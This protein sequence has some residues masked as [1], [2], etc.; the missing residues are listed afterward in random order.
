[1]RASAIL[2]VLAGCTGTTTPPAPEP[3]APEPQVPERALAVAMSRFVAGEDGVQTQPARVSFL[4]PDGAVLGQLEDPESNVFHK[5]MPFRGGLLT[6]G[7]DKARVVHWTRQGQT[8]TAEQVLWQAS[9]GGEHDRM[10]DI[11]LGD[12]DGDGNQE[13]VVATHDQGVVAVLDQA[14]DDS[15]TWTA[16]EL[17]RTPSTFVHEIELGDLDG[18]GTL[19][20]YATPSQPNRSSGA[21]Q[22][23]R[24]DR[25][26][27]GAQGYAHS[28]VVELSDT[29]AKEILVTDLGSG[30]QLFAVAEG[31]V[32][33]AGGLKEPVRIL[34]LDPPAAESSDQTWTSVP[35][36]TLLGE[37]Q[38]RFLVPGDVDGDGS[39]ELVATGMTS[40]VWLLEP[41]PE[42]TLSA[43]QVD[44]SSGGF[45]QAA[46][47]ADLDGDG[48]P[49]LYV[50]SEPGRGAP[51]QLRR[52]AWTEGRSKREVLH[53]FQGDGIVWGIADVRWGE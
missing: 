30:D 32:G 38:S 13:L 6:I 42:G 9:F 46:H 44:G 48:H 11:E 4:G 15:G 37:R 35:V 20:I 45:E 40:G 31:V 24:V 21:S 22:P 52:Y 25:W 53:T 16:T 36:A 1:V 51:R 33:P 10:R 17:S 19:E 39:V 43:K 5:V 29:H 28:T 34:R 7:G 12:V 3:P 47:L 50:A 26:E 49:E 2:L 41:G 8:W 18:D 23:G 27:H 14:S